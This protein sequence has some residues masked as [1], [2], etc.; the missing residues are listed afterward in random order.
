[1]NTRWFNRFFSASVLLLLVAVLA[2]ASQGVTV[3]A[4]ATAPATATVPAPPPS[5]MRWDIVALGIN[6]AHDTVTIAPGGL[7]AAAANDGSYITYTGTGTFGPS[8]SDPVT[9]GGTWATSNPA[10]NPTGSGNYTVT[11]FVS[12]VWDPGKLK[13]GGPFVDKIANI[14]D[15]SGGLATLTIAYTNKDGSAAGTGILILSCRLGNTFSI[16]E[17]VIGS[18][19]T[20]LYFNPILHVADPT[21]D[22]GLMDRVTFFHFVH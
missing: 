1:M 11:G 3:N 5:K 12:F 19:G 9:G 13:P 10:D 8:P 18:K 14:Q 15:T 16:T 4:Q 17:G 21:A 20:T 22:G 2:L 7:E 6:A